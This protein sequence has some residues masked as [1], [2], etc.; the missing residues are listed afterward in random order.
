M[1]AFAKMRRWVISFAN[2]FQ[3]RSPPKADKT[4]GVA[5]ASNVPLMTGNRS[6]QLRWSRMAIAKPVFG[7][8]Q[9]AD[10]DDI[11]MPD[12]LVAMIQKR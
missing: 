1:L 7:S 5:S 2:A 9:T 12:N 3:R 10:L 11:T 8:G 6:R 4:D